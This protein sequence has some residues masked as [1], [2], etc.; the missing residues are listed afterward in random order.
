MET[1]EGRI[2]RRKH[3]VNISIENRFVFMIF[4]KNLMLIIMSANRMKIFNIILAI[5]K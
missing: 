3:K 5:V 1:K 2:N 4:D